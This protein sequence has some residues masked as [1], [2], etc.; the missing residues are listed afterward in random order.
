MGL[1][2]A[3]FVFFGLTN[4]FC[5]AIF[6]RLARNTRHTRELRERYKEG[7]ITADELGQAEALEKSKLSSLSM[8]CG[9]FSLRRLG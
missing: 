5:A 8:V 9:L 6:P 1:Y 2:T 3:G 4:T 7:E